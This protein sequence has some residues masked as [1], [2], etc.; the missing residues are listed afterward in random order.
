MSVSGTL[1]P[2]GQ[3]GGALEGRILQGGTLEGG[4]LEGRILEGVRTLSGHSAR[5]SG[6][7]SSVRVD[8]RHSV[9]SGGG[10]TV[11]TRVLRVSA[12]LSHGREDTI[13]SSVSSVS[14]VSTDTTDS[15]VSTIS[16]TSQ[17]S[18]VS[19]PCHPALESTS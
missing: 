18:T 9:R 10:R 1:Q 19:R 12:L 5:N 13:L 3:E 2:L 4:T 7:L 17:V 14:S 8:A 11:S 16:Q 6:Y 15:G